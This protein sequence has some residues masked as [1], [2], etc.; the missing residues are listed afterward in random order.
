MSKECKQA[1]NTVISV[2]IILIVIIVIIANI[3]EIGMLKSGLT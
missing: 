3:W 2:A 1:R